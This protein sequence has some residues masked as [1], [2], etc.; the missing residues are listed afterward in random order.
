MM[1]RAR[2]RYPDMSE[3]GLRTIV[4][5]LVHHGLLERHPD[6]TERW[7]LTADGSDYLATAY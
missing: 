7:R 5:V 1:E 2:L 3:D 6:G 4:N